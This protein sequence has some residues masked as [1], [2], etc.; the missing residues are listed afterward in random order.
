MDSSQTEAKEYIS[1]WLI[2]VKETELLSDIPHFPQFYVLFLRPMENLLWLEP[3]TSFV[4]AFQY[5]RQSTQRNVAPGYQQLMPQKLV[6][7]KEISS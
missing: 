6:Y 7:Q 1:R 2:L 4:L 5:G 3:A